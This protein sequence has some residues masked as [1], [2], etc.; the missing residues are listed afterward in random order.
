VLGHLG[1][2][3]GLQ[4][5]LGQLVKEPIGADQI[6]SLLFGLCQQLFGQ[7]PLI[8]FSSHGLECF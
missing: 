8:Q 4:H 5:V 7:L 1:V 6:D 2:Q 3:R